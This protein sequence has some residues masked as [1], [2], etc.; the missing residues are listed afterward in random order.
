MVGKMIFVRS[1]KALLVSF[2]KLNGGSA[3]AAQHGIVLC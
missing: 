2:A 1:Q 3:I